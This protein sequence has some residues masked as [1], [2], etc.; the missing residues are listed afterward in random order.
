MIDLKAISV[1]PDN[2]VFKGAVLNANGFRVGVCKNRTGERA[3]YLAFPEAKHEWLT[4]VLD[5]NAA[6]AITGAIGQALASILHA[7]ADNNIKAN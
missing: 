4:I 1:L 3:I 2:E 5:Q 6:A 7:A